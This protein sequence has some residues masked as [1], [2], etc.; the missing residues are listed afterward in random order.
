MRRHGK[1]IRINSGYTVGG[2]ELFLIHR[3]NN[4]AQNPDNENYSSKNQSLLRTAIMRAIR[5]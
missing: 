1:I 5:N 3:N 2:S 4:Q